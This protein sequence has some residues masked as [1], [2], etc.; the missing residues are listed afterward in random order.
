MVTDIIEWLQCFGHHITEAAC[1]G[2]RFARLPKSYYSGI[3]RRSGD[4][5]LGYDCRFQQQAAATS[6]RLAVVNPTL[7]NLVFSGWAGTSHCH[8]CFSLSHCSSDCETLL[9]TQRDTS[10]PGN[11]LPNNPLS[12]NIQSYTMQPT[13]QNQ[14]HQTRVPTTAPPVC[15]SYNERPKPDCLFPNCRFEHS[16]YWCHNNPNIFSKCHKAIFCPNKTSPT[17]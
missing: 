4:C 11:S 13:S 15:D 17:H 7:W 1:Q 16:C 6:T 9:N 8:Y 12:N 3:S 2:S 14:P 10:T 5:W